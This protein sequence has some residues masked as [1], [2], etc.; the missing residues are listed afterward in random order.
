MPPFWIE[1]RWVKLPGI[2]HGVYFT[3]CV[4]CVQKIYRPTNGREYCGD[5]TAKPL[6][7]SRHCFI[8]FHE[9]YGFELVHRMKARD[10]VLAKA[11][12]SRELGNMSHSGFSGLSG[13]LQIISFAFE[14]LT[15][16]TSSDEDS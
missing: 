15:I 2:K 12:V 11:L 9:S 3:E 4:Q 6:I 7:C 1:H 5:C 8:K 13:L 16:S 14:P 10:K